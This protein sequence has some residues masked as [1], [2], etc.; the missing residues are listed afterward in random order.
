[1]NLFLK[2]MKKIKE[3]Q[4]N[5]DLILE[6]SKKIFISYRD[7]LLAKVNEGTS[8]IEFGEVGEFV[9]GPFGGSLKKNIFVSSGFA[10]YEQQHPI[11][12]QTTSFRYFIDEKKFNE[13]KRFAV[14]PNDILMSCSGTFGKMTIVQH[15]SPLGI[16]NQALL[17]ISLSSEVNPEYMKHWMQ[18][19]HFQKSLADSVDGAALQNVPAVAEMK[20]F[21]VKVP[22][23]EVQERVVS[24][25]DEFETDGFEG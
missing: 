20:K 2:K 1:M 8:E 6:E 10:V 16:I 13:M 23:L 14:K 18:S 24:K 3:K 7:S 22:P 19:Q 15:D 5:D 25:L 12:D 17:K 9:R 11:N 21:R 4:M